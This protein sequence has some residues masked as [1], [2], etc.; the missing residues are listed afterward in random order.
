MVVALELYIARVGRVSERFSAKPA[1]VVLSMSLA[2]QFWDY[3]DVL[4][5]ALR[6]TV[7]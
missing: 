5:N 2:L 1:R 6:S 4:L 7:L 3:R